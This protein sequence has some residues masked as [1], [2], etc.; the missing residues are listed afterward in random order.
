M[1]FAM[2]TMSAGDHCVG[3]CDMDP[4][5]PTKRQAA[6]SRGPEQAGVSELSSATHIRCGEAACAWAMFC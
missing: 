3:A 4:Q 5:R 6:P 1:D 2:A